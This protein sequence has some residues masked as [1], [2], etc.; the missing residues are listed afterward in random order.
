MFDP[1]STLWQGLPSVDQ[2]NRWSVALALYYC[3]TIQEP[4]V[5]VKS[6][7]KYRSGIHLISL[8][9][10]V[11]VIGKSTDKVLRRSRLM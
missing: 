9:E 5:A 11:F 7:H 2:V 8:Q 1:A 3:A 4:L 10:V 6:D